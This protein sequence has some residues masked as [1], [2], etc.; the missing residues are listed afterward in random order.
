MRTK[1]R[2]FFKPI[3]VLVSQFGYWSANLVLGRTRGTDGSNLAPS[4]GESVNHRFLR[5][6]GNDRARAYDRLRRN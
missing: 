1:L 2:D 4:R 5:K 3:R 6:L